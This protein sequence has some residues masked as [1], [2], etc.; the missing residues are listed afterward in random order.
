MI[1]ED[2]FEKNWKKFFSKADSKDKIE[3]VYPT[4]NID[5]DSSRGLVNVT[6]NSSYRAEGID[7]PSLIFNS[8]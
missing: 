6:I 2:V 1:K 8:Q 4:V 7:Y 5:R 3:S